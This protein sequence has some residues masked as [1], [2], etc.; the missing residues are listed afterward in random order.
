[1]PVLLLMIGIIAA[2]VVFVFGLKS[3]PGDGEIAVSDRVII[4]LPLAILVAVASIIISR[5]LGFYFYAPKTPGTI[6][7]QIVSLIILLSLWSKVYGSSVKNKP[8]HAAIYT[9]R[10][11]WIQ[12]LLGPGRHSRWKGFPFYLDWLSEKTTRQSFDKVVKELPATSGEPDP[13]TGALLIDGTMS[14][15]GSIKYSVNNQSAEAFSLFLENESEDGKAQEGMEDSLDDHMREAMRLAFARA[16]WEKVLSGD[17]PTAQ[18]IVNDVLESLLGHGYDERELNGGIQDRFGLGILIHAFT[19][20]EA[21][22]ERGLGDVIGLRGKERLEA[23]AEQEQN[24]RFLQRVG[25]IKDALGVDGKVAVDADQV[26]RQKVT[27]RIIDIQGLS[28]DSSAMVFV[29][30][31]GGEGD[32]GGKGQAATPSGAA[33]KRFLSGKQKGK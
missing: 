33:M 25:D 19:F 11:R 5:F 27:K 1:M 24:R 22:G 6:F 10:G 18:T 8:R 4:A 23:E 14:A 21:K 9:I 26:E 17:A 28:G 7:W 13:H 12:R 31:E 29:S 30:D 16:D 2:V 32:S 20:S 3:K 15:K